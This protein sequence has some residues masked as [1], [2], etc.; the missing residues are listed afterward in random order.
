MMSDIMEDM[1]LRVSRLEKE[2]RRFQVEKKK[3]EIF[4][5]SARDDLAVDQSD[6]ALGDYDFVFIYPTANI[7]IHGIT[8]GIEGRHLYIRNVSGTNT[9]AFPHQSGTAT[10]ANRIA[11][12][13]IGTITLGVRQTAHFIYV[14]NANIVTGS[15][16]WLLLHP[17]S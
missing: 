4:N 13:S 7:T 10:A 12:V 9:I 14:N 15:T 5:V 2:L 11:T 3:Y 6:Y 17:F 8:N 16:R 1:V